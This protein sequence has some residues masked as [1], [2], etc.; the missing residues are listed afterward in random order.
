MTKALLT[1]CV[2]LLLLA[3][4]TASKA[5]AQATSQ[6]GARAHGGQG[7]LSKLDLTADQKAQVK[8]ILEQMH[9]DVQAAT[10][11]A[12]KAK[13]RKAAFEKIKTS[14]LTADQLKKLAAM[15]GAH[16]GANGNGAQHPFAGL[17]KKLGLTDDQ[18]A[19]AKTILQQ[20]HKD[21]QAATDKADKMKIMK[22]AFEKIKTSV[23]T[24]D[25]RKKLTDLQAERKEHQQEKAAAK[26]APTT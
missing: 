2:S 22:A 25:Q 11:K 8:A 13:I 7:P 23:L 17:A 21:A 14:I 26:T 18:K 9:K 19:Q 6:P 5:M 24:D 3:G 1:G 12:D 15:K 10:D 16:A 4:L 20:A